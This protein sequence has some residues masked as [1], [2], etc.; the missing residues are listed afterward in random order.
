M[1]QAAL[2]SVRKSARWKPR[3]MEKCR[4]AGRSAFMRA[5][6]VGEGSSC[7]RQ[8]TRRSATRAVG[9]AVEMQVIAMR[10]VVV[11]TEHRVEE[12]AGAGVHVAQEL[13][14]VAVRGPVRRDADLAAIGKAEGRDVQGIGGRV[15]AATSV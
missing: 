8:N 7:R 12:A 1:P 9:A 5:A 6:P 3:I 11:R 4:G 15:L 10:G 13:R 2:A 14:R